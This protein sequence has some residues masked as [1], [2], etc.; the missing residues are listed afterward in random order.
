MQTTRLRVWVDGA[1]P[2]VV[3][4]G[5][6]VGVASYAD[7]VMYPEDITSSESSSSE[8]PES[9][10]PNIIRTSEIDLLLRTQSD[11]LRT[12]CDITRNIASLEDVLANVPEGSGQ[13]LYDNV[14]PSSSSSA[15]SESS[16]SE[17]SSS[18]SP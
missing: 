9:S 7:M 3:I 16:L 8:S 4:D 17:S 15:S 14:E 6:F 13:I 5:I 10:K 12:L 2:F 1:C 11:A 18:S